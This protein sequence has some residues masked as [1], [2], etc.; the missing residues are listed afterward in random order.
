MPQKIYNKLNNHLFKQSDKEQAAFIFAK[1]FKKKAST[2]FLFKSWHL[3]QPNEY[4]YQSTGFIE[5]KDVTRQN[6]I[7]RATKLDASIIEIHSHLS[8]HRAQFSW[9][10]LEGFQ[11]FVPHLW[12]RLKAK[13]YAAIVFSKS[14]FDGLVWVDDPRVPRQ[15]TKITLRRFP[16][17][18]NLYP[19]GL[20]LRER[21]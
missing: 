7:V 17:K 15:L 5:L 11:E 4:E 18:R 2:K 21:T 8:E 14:D 13:P 10:D 1:V 9:S 16:R 20:T 3:V 6:I 12:W 19:S